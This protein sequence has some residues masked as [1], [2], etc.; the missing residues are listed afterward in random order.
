MSKRK[1]VQKILASQHTVRFSDMVTLVVAFGFH[2]SRVSGSQHIIFHPDVPELVNLQDVSGRAKP[3][4]IR[5]FL[6][7]VERYDLKLPE[8]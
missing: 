8:E 5:Q 7:L 1:L 3:Y 2:L 6:K 4:Q